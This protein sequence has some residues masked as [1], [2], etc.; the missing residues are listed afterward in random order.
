VVVRCLL[1]D[2]TVGHGEGVPRDYVT[3]ETVDSALALLARSDLAAQLEPCPDFNRAAGMC[4]RLRLAAVPGDDRGIQ[5]N[6]ARCALELA[7]LDAFGRR[8]GEPLS[9]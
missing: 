8:Y 6:A 5:G 3:G 4:E 7:L 9:N 1:D 2:G